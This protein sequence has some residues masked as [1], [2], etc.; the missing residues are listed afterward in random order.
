MGLGYIDKD[1]RTFVADSRGRPVVA[2][3]DSDQ[4][5]KYF[6]WSR[7][8]VIDVPKIVEYK[9]QNDVQRHVR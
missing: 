7:C 5:F 1:G 4:L 9:L 2:S 6:D 8:T 3:D